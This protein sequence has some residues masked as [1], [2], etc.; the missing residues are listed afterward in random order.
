MCERPLR[1]M[2][3]GKC[4]NRAAGQFTELSGQRFG[5]P[6]RIGAALEARTT[7]RHALLAALSRRS[8]EAR[9][10]RAI[11]RERDHV[12]RRGAA[13]RLATLLSL[14]FWLTACSSDAAENERCKREAPA[15]AALR[16]MPWGYFLD[17]DVARYRPRYQLPSAE[18]LPIG[19]PGA[20][21]DFGVSGMPPCSRARGTSRT[22]WMAHRADET[23]TTGQLPQSV[24]GRRR[25]SFA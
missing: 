16:A 23:L 18:F 20:A 12:A 25:V 21:P 2:L 11:H 9:D 4:G 17:T 24:S 6:G 13:M 3:G 1:L 10:R 15:N 8:W 19:Q 5:R 14:L 7:I 22:G